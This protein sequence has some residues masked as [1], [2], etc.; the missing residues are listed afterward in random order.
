MCVRMKVY[1]QWQIYVVVYR[2]AR[3]HLLACRLSAGAV[4]GWYAYMSVL[5]YSLSALVSRGK[6]VNNS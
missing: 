5:C 1:V 6:V 3:R 2:I 4:D